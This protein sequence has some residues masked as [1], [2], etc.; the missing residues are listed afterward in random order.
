MSSIQVYI[1]YPQENERVESNLYTFRIGTVPEASRV[2]VSVDGG[3]W[4]V[5]RPGAGYWWHDW[6]GFDPGEHVVRARGFAHDG[7]HAESKP[8]RFRRVR[9]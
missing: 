9:P 5:C 7:S 1:D 8:R 4:L 6:I 3:S 2:E